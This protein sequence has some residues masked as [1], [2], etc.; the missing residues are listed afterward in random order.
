MFFYLNELVGV[1]MKSIKVFL[2]FYTAFIILGCNRISNENSSSMASSSTSSSS[3]QS[4]SSKSSEN[5][6]NSENFNV[7]G[8]TVD[9]DLFNDYISQNKI[10]KYYNKE[11]YEIA[12]ITQ[13][14][15]EVEFKYKNIWEKEM[16]Y[17]ILNLTKMLDKKDK[18][19]FIT[20]QKQWEDSTIRNLELERDILCD[21]NKYDVHLGSIFRP[22]WA[23]QVREAYRQRTIKIK[24][25]NYLLETQ[26]DKPKPI[27]DCLSLKFK[28]EK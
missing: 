1:S 25:L 15:Y 26:T 18:N 19:F 5:L 16:G 10:D 17:S 14:M 20:N 27:S 13:E 28:Y 23:S 3:A 6:S 8:F 9:S 12:G 11:V 7:Y 21:S 24:Y 2:I 22:L 4:I